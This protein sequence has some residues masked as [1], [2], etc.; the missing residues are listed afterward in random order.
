[1]LCCCRGRE[2]RQFSHLLKCSFPEGLPGLPSVCWVFGYDGPVRSL[3]FLVHAEGRCRV[4]MSSGVTCRGEEYVHSTVSMPG[5]PCYSTGT[6]PDT[7]HRLACAWVTCW[8]H[9][10]R[11]T[12][13]MRTGLKVH[14]HTP[15]HLC[16]MERGW[17]SEDNTSK[18]Y[19]PQESSSSISDGPRKKGQAAGWLFGPAKPSL[20]SWLEIICSPAL[21]QTTSIICSDFSLNLPH[22]K[23]PNL[24]IWYT[25]YQLKVHVCWGCSAAPVQGGRHQQNFAT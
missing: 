5:S 3:Q 18:E 1:M 4:N 21:W 15:C 7:W 22:A 17:A 10:C 6:H 8:V 12:C 9:L 2:C 14:G 13:P 24:D 11:Q 19:L 23:S 16:L 25:F 20:N